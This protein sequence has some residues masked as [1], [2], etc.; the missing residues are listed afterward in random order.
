MARTLPYQILPT[1]WRYNLKTSILILLLLGTLTAGGVQL[2]NQSRHPR[3]EQAGQPQHD[4]ALPVADSQQERSSAVEMTSNKF[5]HPEDASGHE[6]VTAVMAMVPDEFR[7]HIS[8]EQETRSATDPDSMS[9]LIQALERSLKAIRSIP[10][11]T[12]TLEQQVQKGGRTLDPDFIDLKLRHEPFSVYL[13][14]QDDHQEVLY[15]HGENDGRL[16]ARPTRGLASLRR[17]WR[18]NPVSSQAMKDSRYP[19]TEIGIE[20][21]NTMALQFYLKQKSVQEGCTCVTSKTMAEGRPAATY[22]VSF[23]DPARSPEYARSRLTF[24]MESH[25]L[26]SVESHTWSENGQVGPLLELYRYHGFQPD[27]SLADEDFSEHH[28][29][30]DFHRK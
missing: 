17:I 22:E 13:K 29:D 4:Q 28:P 27:R 18:L 5:V 7:D 16:L 19:L 12:A 24:D 1:P 8:S 11:Y 10:S 26:V 30:Y 15:V 6:D 9:S 23:A 21:L 2:I 25:L 20:K 14:W 3:L